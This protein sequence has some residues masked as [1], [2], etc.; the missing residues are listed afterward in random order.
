MVS[1][2]PSQPPAL[3]IGAIVRNLSANKP[4]TAKQITQIQAWKQW[5]EST[6]AYDGSA[7]GGLRDVLN[8]LA[9]MVDGLKSMSDS[10]TAL[11]SDLQRRV[12]A[13]EAQPSAPFPASS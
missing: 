9:V 4:L 1:F 12:A 3:D 2:K 10:Q 8:A 6:N 7:K 11:L 13:L 5:L